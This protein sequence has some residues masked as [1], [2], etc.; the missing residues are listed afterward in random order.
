MAGAAAGSYIGL[1]RHRNEM[2]EQREERRKWSSAQ[3]MERT[4]EDF[5]RELED[6]DFVVVRD[7]LLG[8]AEPLERTGETAAA[9]YREALGL[10][11][12]QYFQDVGPGFPDVDYQLSLFED[13]EPVRS[14]YI[15]EDL[16]DRQSYSETGIESLF[17][18]D[19][20]GAV[21]LEEYR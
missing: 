7:Y 9:L 2:D 17:D 20:D 21:S 13:G 19:M 16:V 10:D 1:K 6:Q 5:S 15:G 11:C 3:D 18:E 8:G 4:G 14:F 12:T